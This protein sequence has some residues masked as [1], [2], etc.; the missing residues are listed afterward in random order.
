MPRTQTAEAVFNTALTGYQEAL[1]DPSYAGQILAMTCPLIGNT[2]VN[3]ADVE[4]GRVQVAGFVIRQLARRHSSSRA[5][6]DLASYLDQHGVLGIEGV[7]TRAMTRRLRAEG[8]MRAA[9][10]NDSRLSD[11][12]LVEAARAAPSMAS[13]NLV[14][15]VSCREPSGW[16]RPLLPWTHRRIAAGSGPR[17]VALDCGVKEQILRHLV[18]RGCSVQVLPHDVRQ[19]AFGA[20]LEQADGL[21]VS[22]GPG[23]PESVE[24]TIAL[25]REALRRDSFPIFGICMGHQLLSLAIGAA[26]YK[27]K[28]GHRGTNQPVL[29]RLSGRVEI[30][31]QNHGFAVDPGS[32]AG[33]GATPTHVHLNDQT[34]AGICLDTRPVYSVQHHPEASPGPHD[35]GYLFDAFVHL[36]R[37][38]G[39]AESALRGALRGSTTVLV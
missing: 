6:T 26:T 29:N 21:F 30:T 39:D 13:Q 17:V 7:D 23:D 9:I 5:T 10:S 4:S 14:Q 22:N 8:A 11:L 32:L 3:L 27:L 16:D 20:A 37:T 24:P 33:T 1:T 15:G 38:G 12:Q 31:S 35:S 28:F 18:D 36:M 19:D 2:G 25:L 34:I